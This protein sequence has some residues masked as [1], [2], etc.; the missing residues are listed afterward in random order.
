MFTKIK[1]VVGIM[2]ALAVCISAWAIKTSFAIVVSGAIITAKAAVFLGVVYGL[3][4]AYQY[5]SG[6]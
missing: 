6:K 4:L 3:Y 5:F 1:T 2:L